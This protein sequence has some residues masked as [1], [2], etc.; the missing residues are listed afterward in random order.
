MSFRSPTTDNRSPCIGILALQGNVA[1]HRKALEDLHMTVREVRTPKD[2][3]GVFALV[4]PGG[5]STVM[6]KLMQESG[7]DEAIVRRVPE[8][9]PVLATCAGAIILSDTHLKLMDISVDRNAYGSQVDSFEAVLSVEGKDMKVTFIR[10]PKITRTGYGVEVLARHDG[11]P[12]IV[13]QNSV[14]ATTCHPEM[15]GETLLHA[16]LLENLNT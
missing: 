4:I 13:R 5:E 7:L 3:E 8:G 14:I 2:I 10:A 12:V 11:N 16:M 9:L 15:R 1:E 6:M